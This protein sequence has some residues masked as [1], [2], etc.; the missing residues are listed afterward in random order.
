MSNNN[1][2]AFLFPHGSLYPIGG[3]KMAFEYANRFAADGWDVTLVYPSAMR[4]TYNW[5]DIA[6]Y[7]GR[8]FTKGYKPQWYKL[9]HR[10]R[11]K[12]VLTLQHF[13]YDADMA[14]VGTYVTTIVALNKYQLPATQKINFVQDKEDGEADIDLY[15]TYHYAMKKIV[16]SKWLNNIMS[17]ID[18]HAFLVPNGFDFHYFGLVT[19]PENRDRHRI[20]FMYHDAARKAVDVA[21]KAF[22]MVKRK[23]P[24]LRV[25]LFSA[26]EKPEGLAD[27]YDFYHTP[28]RE[29]HVRLYN[30]AAIYVGSS[31]VE[32]WG[33]TVGEAMICGCAVACTDNQ[34]YLEMAKD[35]ET[36]L[37]SPV[38]DAD[39]LA[40]NI[41][42]LIEDD[43]LRFRIAH[44][45]N[46]FIQDFDIEKTYQKFKGVV[47]I[48]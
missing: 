9:D 43:E 31:K 45:G 32:G 47:N 30:E 8:L 42:R 16:I 39:A 24:Q 22:D 20:I 27:W 6:R 25:T 23:H 29:T 7:V 36:A 1:K 40:R 46:E 12:W 26:Y 11:Q 38:G 48:K 14:V 34:G 3:F 19:P 13:R 18:E 17:Q 4:E 5:R 33:L 15:E 28:D 10:I 2:I 35:D 41:V 44:S 37:V 21:L